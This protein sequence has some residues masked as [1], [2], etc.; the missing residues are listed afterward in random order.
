MSQTKVEAPFVEGVGGGFKNVIINGDMQ[1]FQRATSATTLGDSVYQTV[2]RFGFSE[3]SGG[4]ATSELDNLSVADQA[5]TGQARALE[6]NCTS[7]DTSI[8]AGDR[9]YIYY[10]IEAQDCR[11][12]LYGTSAAKTLTL[13]FWVKSNL[14]GNFP[15]TVK[16]DDNTVY[17]LPLSYSISSANTWEKKTITWT[18]TEGSTS[19]I[20]ESGAA[21]NND[22]GRG[23]QIFWGL[24]W[25][26]NYTGSQSGTPTWTSSA[27]F[28]D[29][30][31]T[32]VNFYSSTSNNLYITGVQL[33]VGDAASD[34]EHLP[35]SVQL[36]RCS[37]YY[38]P[39]SYGLLSSA[40]VMFGL[41]FGG[42]D[43]S[44]VGSDNVMFA[45]NFPVPMRDA[46][47]V[48]VGSKG[49]GTG[50]ASTQY[51]SEY[52]CQLYYT[53][54]GA[55]SVWLKNVVAASEL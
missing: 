45:Y 46:P 53:S 54:N 12:F 44:N 51:I 3:G 8:A 4:A 47:T 31:I 11:R 41:A 32:F 1:I 9:S 10:N 24:V 33:E 30:D 36:Q 35:H 42:L 7:T 25:G 49:S 13:S 52:G 40:P 15:L 48:T 38:H 20:T 16:K 28:A 5:T 39:L 27:Y 43:G 2:D 19:L 50:S 6:L 55:S 18:P 26:S 22:N 21:I 34:F 23:F 17:Y 14:T 29:S 37:R